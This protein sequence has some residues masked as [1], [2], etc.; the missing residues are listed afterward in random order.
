MTG[1]SARCLRC[2]HVGALAL[3]LSSCSSDRRDRP[4]AAANAVS[5]AERVPPPS[6]QP[7]TLPDL[8]AAAATVREELQQRYEAAVSAS[9]ALPAQERAR[10]YG[11]LG[12]T[13]LAAAFFDEAARA[14][15]QAEALEPREM[16][17]PYLR[18]HALVRK[19]DRDGA[20][21]AFTRAIDLQP[22]YVPALV[23]LGD[24]HLDLGR[25]DEAQ[26]D[27]VRALAVEPESATALF[28]AGRAAL[29][30][31]AY[32]DAAE[33]MEQALRVDPRA[34]A[35][36]YP[37][38]MAYRAL[39]RKDRADTLLA[40]RGTAAPALHDPVLEGATI[41]LDTAVSYENV[42]MEALRR[43][44][45][46]GAIAAFRHGLQVAPDDPSLQY[47]MASAMI[48]G[49]D[50]AGAERE[51]RAIASAHPGFAKAHFSLG[52]ILDRQGHRAEASEEYERA[53]RADP[54]MVDARL[55]LADTLRALG[56]LRPAME[57]YEA[58]VDLDPNAAA[59]WIGGAQTLIDLGDRERARDWIARGMRLH[60][61]RPEWARLQQSSG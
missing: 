36:N 56:R 51:F 19:G 8:S 17:W 33:Y 57:H 35:I 16:K 54:R 23:W 2:L 53:V 49:G 42:G 52:A 7:L 22:T 41:V 28:G 58:A 5:P 32:G 18:A 3:L 31:G 24:M 40:G 9:P 48:A 61:T 38:A 21:L 37:L 43:Q 11:D 44:D 13:L 25:A 15:A 6:S 26:R 59:A 27:F 45:W 34:T 30:R 12:H 60:P 1:R 20:S 47:W 14:Y 10:R 39:G 50:A 55:R 46:P 4:P 29:T